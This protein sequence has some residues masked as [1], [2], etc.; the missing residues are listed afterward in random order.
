MHPYAFLPILLIP[1]RCPT[2]A[3]ANSG[4][5]EAQHF[6]DEYIGHKGNAANN[7][8]TESTGKYTGRSTNNLGREFIM[9]ILLVL[10]ISLITSLAI[11]D[12]E[13]I[14]NP[15]DNSLYIP[16][17]VVQGDTLGVTYS[18]QMMNQGDYNFSVTDTTELVGT[19]SGENSAVYDPATNSLYLPTVFVTGDNSGMSYNVQLIDQGDFNFSISDITEIKSNAFVLT[20]PVMEDGGE[21]PATYS[22]DD[23]GISPP[24]AWSGAPDGTNSYALA[25]HHEAGPGDVHWYWVMYDIG[26]DSVGLDAGDTSAGTFGTNG[27]NQLREYTPPCSQGPGEKKYTITLY[28]LSEVPDVSSYSSVDR[29]VLLSAVSGITL[30]TASMEVT[31]ERFPESDNI[32]EQPGNEGQPTYNIEQALSDQAQ[33]NTIAYGGL[34]FITGNMCAD[35]F[36]PPGKVA[37][38]F[39]YQYLRDNTADGMGHN[40]DFVTNSA[41][42]VLSI[43]NDEQMQ[44]LIYLALTQVDL[45]NEFAYKRIPL[46]NAFRIADSDPN[47]TLNKQA[48]INYATELQLIDA[49][50]SL[51]RAKLFGSIIRSLTDSQIAF[52]DAMVTGGFYEWEAIDHQIDPN[53]YSVDE[54]VLMMTFAS[55]MFGWY[56]GSV[57]ADTYIAP[58]RQANYF[59]SFYM[60]DAPAMGNPGY[61][62]DETLTGNKGAEFLT[63]LSEP[64]AALVTD[65]VDTQYDNLLTIVD[66]REAISIE[67]RKLLVQDTVDENKIFDLAATYGALDGENSYNYA[68][69]FSSV[70]SDL[71]TAQF[72]DLMALRDLDEYPCA[73]TDIY[74]YS[75]KSSLTDLETKIDL[76]EITSPLL[77]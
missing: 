55:E 64:Q 52:L 56:A 62:I 30:D 12:N 70:G 61:T 54:H 40:T 69:N 17:V 53:D 65:L 43:L 74:I 28:A 47:H 14:Y 77:D 50:I 57:E 59:G 42:N 71:S 26:V 3:G 72:A 31:F 75:E 10:A 67:L 38:F 32:P 9:N 49:E 24:L 29:D 58:E 68:T 16:V 35:S 45:I 4:A 21:M 18:V 33:Q 76:D 20:S 7:Q 2:V 63:L 22:C 13:A 25:M 60:K 27:V 1:I 46:I 19:N 66:V 48:V 11:A 5:G 39:G 51:Q 36:I 6:G 41:N 73:E 44:Q 15:V 34:A 8:I 23:E 37:D